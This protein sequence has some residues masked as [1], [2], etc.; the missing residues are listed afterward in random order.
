[1]SEIVELDSG[2]L[3]FMGKIYPRR[4]TSIGIVSRYADAMGMGAI[5]PPPA[6]ALVEGKNAIVDGVHRIK[7][8]DLLAGFSPRK[9]KVE[10][11]GEMTE[12]QAFEE[13]VRRNA[14]HGSRFDASDL[15]KIVGIFEKHGRNL[16]YVS[17]VL[18]MSKERLEFRRESPRSVTYPSGAR[19]RTEGQPSPLGMGL[20]DLISWTI[21]FVKEGKVGDDMVDSL[22]QLRDEINSFLARRREGSKDE[23][24][25]PRVHGGNDMR[26]DVMAAAG[27]E[28]NLEEEGNSGNGRSRN[29][30]DIVI[31]TKAILNSF[32][33]ISEEEAR[34]TAFQ[35]LS[36]FGYE[37]RCLANNLE[38]GDNQAFYML[39][40]KGLVKSTSYETI[41]V[42]GRPWRTVEFELVYEKIMEAASVEKEGKDV[43]VYAGLPEEAWVR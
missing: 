3:S 18:R 35:V 19:N 28:V 5:F 34:K 38:E 7:A 32:P 10:F 33:G 13:S 20:Q 21:K 39:E 6:V 4:S 36:Y 1:M 42:D 14:I 26:G 41:L 31:F 11:L 24:K 15:R 40:D 43:D 25:E 37:K 23:K 30:V 29:V 27:Q 16:S 22:T 8:M 17:G 12:E 9:V 2:S